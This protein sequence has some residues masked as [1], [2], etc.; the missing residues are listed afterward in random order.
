[1]AHSSQPARVPAPDE[2][3][4]GSA[5]ISPGVVLDGRLGVFHRTD[6]WLAVA[7]L[8]YGY[9]LTA[10]RHGGLFPLWGMES[11]AAR[12]AA[13]V[14]DYRPR[15]LLLLGDL[16]HGVGTHSQARELVDALEGCVSGDVVCIAG[17]HDRGPLRRLL[18]FVDEFTLGGYRFH[19]GHDE[20]R[21][22]SGDRSLVQVT[23]HLHP[24]VDFRDGAGLAL[25]LPALLCGESPEIGARWVLPAF[26][27]WAGG[28]NW[29]RFGFG[30]G[31]RRWACSPR[32]VFEVIDD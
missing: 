22:R 17:N 9:E 24:T 21:L 6:C 11:V 13:L 18:P 16:I 28:R 30:A 19:H 32:R 29:R 25:R 31:T 3:S 4:S 26:S 27:P 2:P 7:D 10:R 8:H 5:E 1:M 20:S 23:G 14:R 12:L 15:V